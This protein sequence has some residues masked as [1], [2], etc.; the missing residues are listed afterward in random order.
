MQQQ[1]IDFVNKK[2]EESGG[3]CGTYLV[4]LKNQLQISYDDLKKILSEMHKEKKI[5][6]RKGI[7][8]FMIMKTI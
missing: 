1:I 4:E 5:R 2:H 6:V 8:G 7:N 3:S